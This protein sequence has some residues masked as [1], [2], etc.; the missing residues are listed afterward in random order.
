MTELREEFL[1]A[2]C[3]RQLRNN[4]LA[5]P[6]SRLTLACIQTQSQ[7]VPIATFCCHFLVLLGMT[8]VIQFLGNH[9]VAPSPHLVYRKR[10]TKTLLF[11]QRVKTKTHKMWMFLKS[12]PIC[13]R[14]IQH[15]W[16][17][18]FLVQLDPIFPESMYPTYTDQTSLEIWYFW[19]EDI[20]NEAQLLRTGKKFGWNSWETTWKFPPRAMN[21]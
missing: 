11:E 8:M 12:L 1:V 17:S 19:F 18:Q 14:C 2:D 20:S 13:Q 16:S 4:F 15:V 21:G 10:G 7:K 3:F 6:S 9:L 5:I